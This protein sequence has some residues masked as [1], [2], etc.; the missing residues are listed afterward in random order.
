MKVFNSL[1]A[2]EIVNAECN[3]GTGKALHDT[4]TTSECLT[5]MQ[6]AY[7]VA[8]HMAR[9]IGDATLKAAETGAEVLFFNRV[10]PSITKQESGMYVGRW[11]GSVVVTRYPYSPK[12]TAE[13][14]LQDNEGKEDVING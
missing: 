12:L 5:A 7:D 2:Y 4:Y 6:A 8:A 3:C 14:N 11:R 1:K 13:G 9:I 10:G